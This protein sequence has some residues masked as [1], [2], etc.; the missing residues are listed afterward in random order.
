MTV[1]AL[2]TGTRAV[3]I[4]ADSEVTDTSGL[5]THAHK[6]CALERGGRQVGALAYAGRV[7]RGVALAEAVAAAVRGARSIRSPLALLKRTV[8]PLARQRRSDDD[9]VASALV[10]LCGAG[11]EIDDDGLV[12]EVTRSAIGSG[13][14]VALGAMWRRRG[15]PASIVRGACRAACEIVSSCGGPID[16]FEMPRR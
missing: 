3:A 16:V 6:L 13:S 4:A 1:V 9:D 14:H 5:R 7:V 8:E 10:V 12:V 11:Y 15:A 2:A